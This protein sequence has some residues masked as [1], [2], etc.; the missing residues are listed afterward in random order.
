MQCR[1]P[2]PPSQVLCCIIPSLSPE[3]CV[4][5]R[6]M[7]SRHNKRL[8]VGLLWTSSAAVNAFRSCL[9]QISVSV[10]L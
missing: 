10:F 6:K 3:A 8:S 1:T 4:W 7:A 9:V 2:P 5:Y